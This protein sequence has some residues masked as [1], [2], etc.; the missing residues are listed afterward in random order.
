MSD[1]DLRYVNTSGDT[2]TGALVIRPTVGANTV[3]LNVAATM[4]G[5]ALYI[6]GTGAN[7]ILYT[8][9]GNGRV[10]M[11]TSSPLYDLHVV[12]TAAAG[13]DRYTNSANQGS[14][15]G[16]RKARGTNPSNA[17]TVIDGDEIGKFAFGG[18]DGTNF[19]TS[20]ILGTAVNSAVG[21]SNVKQNFIFA[22]N[23]NGGT[24][25]T[26]T[27]EKMRITSSGAVGI[28]TTNLPNGLKFSVAG[29]M[30][31]RSLYITGTG[32]NPLVYSDV[33]KGMVGINALRA[34]GA[35]HTVGIQGTYAALVASSPGSNSAWFVNTAAPSAGGGAGMQGLIT[36]AP[37]A[38]GQRLG[39]L[40][41]GVRPGVD[42]TGYNTASVEGFAEQPYS[43]GSAQGSYLTFS[44]TSLNA[45][46]RTE[47]MRLTSSGA[48]G[49]GT[50]N[51]PTGLKLNVA[52][53]ISG[54]TL[55]ASNL[56]VSGA[57]VVTSGSMLVSTTKP[58]TGQ[59]L[60]SRQTGVPVFRDPTSTMIWYI[61]GTL[62]SGTRKSANVVMPFG[63]TPTGVDLYATGAPTGAAIIVDINE[64]GTTL[65]STRPQ[66]NASSNTEAGTHAF[67]D[68]D[69]AM[70][71]NVTVDLDQVGSTFAGSG[72]TIM[73]HG[74]R[75]Y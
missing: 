14:G 31:G 40:V 65:F 20:A 17:T 4:S 61:D 35:L 73:L 34:S 29:A 6:T 64:N 26:A 45:S 27:D 50:T 74:T 71:S 48:L 37:T 15:F 72:L 2:M 49:I 23:T 5:R 25:A 30:S 7:P 39:F 44:T 47:R 66:I 18:Y 12:G 57:V 42:A 10:G 8:N 46:S 62:T 3:G 59:L 53:T 21:T 11:G 41:F 63:F 9:I 70:G 33:T 16:A 38:A 55:K 1:G 69:I 24:A 13:V 19:V 28:G 51:L 68:T 75:K 60:I 56:T 52:G 67:N 32:A 54:S 43:L 58:G 22:L 36:Q